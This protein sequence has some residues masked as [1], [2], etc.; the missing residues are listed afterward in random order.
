MDR[1]YSKIEMLSSSLLLT[2]NVL[3]PVLLAIGVNTFIFTSDW[4]NDQSKH[5]PRPG[6]RH[7]LPP[8]YVIGLIWIFL[9]ALLGYAHYRLFFSFASIILLTTIAFCI[10][11]PFLTQ[12]KGRG[13]DRARVMNT[14]TLVFAGVTLAAS[15]GRSDWLATAAIVPLFIWAGYINIV[16]AV[17]CQR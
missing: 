9:L 10:S 11:Y 8:G 16:D 17:E 13:E 14:A 2:L 15:A 1:V 3:I 6:G 7:L 4:N 5:I 12:G